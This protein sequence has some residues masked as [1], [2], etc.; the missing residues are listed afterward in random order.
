MVSSLRD[1]RE[2]VAMNEKSGTEAGERTQNMSLH[3]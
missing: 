1:F 3:I 2:F